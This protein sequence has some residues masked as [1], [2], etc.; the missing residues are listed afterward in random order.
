M[1]EQAGGWFCAAY[2]ILVGAIPV[3]QVARRKLSR[4]QREGVRRQFVHARARLH[5]LG[6][7]HLVAQPVDDLVVEDVEAHRRQSH[8]GHYVAG[9]EPNGH[10]PRLV[11]VLPGVGT[12]YHVAEPD[13]AQA[14]EA[15][16]A[17]VCSYTR[18]YR[19]IKLFIINYRSFKIYFIRGLKIF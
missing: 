13:S 4:G 17:C 18:K 16:V 9:A 14:H 2:V 5:R 1:G 11:E 19:F 15:E 6:L 10:V 7:L 12:G 8:S 3:A